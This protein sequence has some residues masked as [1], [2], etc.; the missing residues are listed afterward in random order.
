MNALFVVLLVAQTKGEI[1]M[2]SANI[3][4][5]S[6]TDLLLSDNLIWIS[7]HAGNPLRSGCRSYTV[8][9]HAVFFLCMCVCLFLVAYFCFHNDL[10]S[11]CNSKSIF[12][13]YFYMSSS[14]LPWQQTGLFHRA[15]SMTAGPYK[16][17]VHT[18]AHKMLIS[19]GPKCLMSLHSDPPP[20]NFVDVMKSQFH[21][22]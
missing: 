20:E 17:N 7:K 11:S 5:Y 6:L 8:H 21:T 12:N 16:I 1:F 9:S 18:D 10:T 2:Y 13:L 3:K 15:P 19:P 4:K 22:V 14:W